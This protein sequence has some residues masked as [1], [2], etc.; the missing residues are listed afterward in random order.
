MPAVLP[1]SPDRHALLAVKFS[2]EIAVYSSSPV[3]RDRKPKFIDGLLF[4]LLQTRILFRATLSEWRTHSSCGLLRPSRLVSCSS[5]SR[6]FPRCLASSRNG[7]STSDPLSCAKHS[8]TS[9][10]RDQI[11]ISSRRERSGSSTMHT[12]G[13]LGHRSVAA[14]VQVSDSVRRAAEL[15]TEREKTREELLQ[16]HDQ[17]YRSRA[18]L[19]MTD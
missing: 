15:R 12:G 18:R 10:S 9:F 11:P 2:L 19:E 4:S 14:L 6:T 17:V 8:H 16:S 13:R 3:S 5:P 1:R 7:C